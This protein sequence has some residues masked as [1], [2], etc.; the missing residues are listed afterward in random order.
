MDN[1]E[2]KRNYKP[3]IAWIIVYMILLIAPLSIF[4]VSKKIGVM[5]SM[6]FSVFALD[7]LLYIIYKG[8]Y[9][10]WFTMGPNFKEAKASRSEE[11]KKYAKLILDL[12]LKMTAVSIVYSI[13]SI[14][15]KF[16]VWVD[17]IIITGLITI[18]S[19]KTIAFKF[20]KY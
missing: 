8:E 5:Y 16:P 14:V 18:A 11:R 1:K 6:M 20:K 7:I 9:V 12:F 17:I 3:L 2:Y 4:E 19:L 13:V 10:Y 15:F